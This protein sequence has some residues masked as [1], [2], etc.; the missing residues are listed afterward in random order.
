MAV[1]GLSLIRY[2]YSGG[3]ADERAR[4]PSTQIHGVYEAGDGY[5]AVRVIG[6]EA[7][8]SVAEATNLDVAEVNPSSSALRDWFRQR[9]RDQIVG[10]L[11]EKVPCAPV[12]TDEELI[13][14]PNV[15]ERDMIIER[16]HPLGFNYRTIAS[17]V[18]FSE[19]PTRFELLPPELGADTVDV[20]RLIGYDDD[21]IRVLMDEGAARGPVT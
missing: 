9:S 1:S 12:V 4:R 10:L 2:L 15:K 6:D 20:L 21:E 5:V 13:R 8:R 11:A 16:R 7:I 14:D 18:K 19:T 17:G 3:A